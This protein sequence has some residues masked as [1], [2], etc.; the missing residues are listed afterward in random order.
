MVRKV[1]VRD[2]R[3]KDRVHTVFRVA[4]KTRQTARSGKPF[5]IVGL[6]DK[7]GDVEARVFDAVDALDAVFSA[8]DYI[9]VEGHV[10]GFHGKPQVVIEKADK[11]DP[12]PLDPAE[13]TPKPGAAGPSA[14][15]ARSE[16]PGRAAGGIR[17]L[18][19]R[20]QDPHLKQLA[21]AFVE[22][23]DFADA[24][25][26]A[27]GARP[28]P[29]ARKGGIADQVLA[30]A[31]LVARLAEQYPSVDRD[32]CV[33]A[34]IAGGAARA[35]A[36]DRN[37]SWEPT[38]EAKLVGESVLAAQFIREQS[39]R[40]SGFPSA[41]VQQLTHIVLAQDG[42]R[43]PQTAEAYAVQMAQTLDAELA[44]GG[45]PSAR[46]ESKRPR[47]EEKKRREKPV[48]GESPKVDVSGDSKPQGAAKLNFKPL[49]ELTGSG[50]ETTPPTGTPAA[51]NGAQSGGVS[52]S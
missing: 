14:T 42:I 51:G 9:L 21:A 12:E 35:R 6:E 29:Y 1:Y 3:E 10:I 37:R 19:E 13:F 46:G 15:A 49:S 32:L 28:G 25:R 11:L 44:R 40:I 47:R 22:G 52:G 4:R 50:A 45:L 33:T 2:L 18:A 38:D 5:L 7:T 23:S 41:L 39:T 20:I 16:E 27:P 30:V 24:L 43:P 34:L 8:G 26:S 17:E 48:T 31:R 36:L